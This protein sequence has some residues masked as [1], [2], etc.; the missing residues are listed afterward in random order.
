MTKTN[1]LIEEENRQFEIF[2][3]KSGNQL[4]VNILSITLNFYFI[5]TKTYYYHKIKPFNF[6]L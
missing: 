1:H 3:L 6:N 5:R 2:F 4:P